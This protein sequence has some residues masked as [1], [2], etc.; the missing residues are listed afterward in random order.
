MEDNE[1]IELYLSRSEQAIS[2]TAVRYGHYCYH[3]A[4]NILA[5]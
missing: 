4:Y 1:I 3:I 2:E 5:N